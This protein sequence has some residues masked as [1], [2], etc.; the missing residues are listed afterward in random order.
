MAE[1]IDHTGRLKKMHKILQEDLEDHLLK[2]DRYLQGEFD[3][4][5]TPD[6]AS[7]E[8][9]MLAERSKSDIISLLV[10]A[11]CQALYLDGFRPGRALPDD[12]DP[13]SIPEWHHFEQSL[14]GSRQLAVHR[15]ATG[16]GHAF[17]E[18]YRD[19]RGRVLTRGLS[20]LRTSALFEDPA[21]DIVPVC[22]QTITREAGMV[23]GKEVVGKGFYWDES[24][25]RYPYTFTT[26]H[27]FTL[28]EPE[29]MKSDE[30]TITRFAAMVDLDG[31]TR[32]VVEPMMPYQDRMNQSV[33]DL[34]V[35]QS[36]GAFT[37][38]TMTGMLP[39]IK[40]DP[41]TGEPELDSN[42]QP[43]ALPVPIHV[44]K[45]L[46]AE[47]PEVRFG[48]LEG[49][50]ME[51]YIQSIEMTLRH[52]AA[53]SQTP[54]H[55]LLG[56]I[57]NL[58]AEALQA[59]ESTLSRKVEEFR[60]AYGQSWERIFILAGRMSGNVDSAEDDHGEVLWRDMEARSMAQISDALGKLR[61]SLDIPGRG[62]WS[63]VPGVTQGEI[64]EWARLK[65][66]EDE[67]LATFGKMRDVLTGEVRGAGATPADGE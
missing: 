36:G 66:E 46:A 14:L 8:F 48:T 17:T 41:E 31:R 51:G 37:T 23:D 38:K 22:A 21:N 11:P 60:V 33:F 15:A 4:P 53:A 3:P 61:E 28:G 56:Q 54:P 39:P 57:A 47:D 65:E 43:Q 55:Y 13:R 44:K 27:K 58:S 63:R 67:A 62:L 59:A 10:N 25:F 16:Y 40:R 35:V 32:G 6:E 24:G 34:L 26:D 29:D 19:K 2:I 12:T 9:V 64:T 30:C 49:T 45:I 42:G 50:P 7:D 1:K 5:Y 18:T 20:P 52:T